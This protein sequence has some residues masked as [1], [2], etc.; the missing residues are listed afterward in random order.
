MHATFH[1]ILFAGAALGAVALTTPPAAA[2]DAMGLFSE[3]NL[4]PEVLAKV[5]ERA[6][7]RESEV[8]AAVE[9]LKGANPALA[10]IVLRSIALPADID[11]AVKS[12]FDA[13]ALWPQ[14]ARLKLCFLDG[15]DA[16]RG[17]V[18]E[19]AAQVFE[20]TN[21][22]L[23]LGD[24]RLHPTGRAADPRHVPDPGLLELYRHRREPDRVPHADVRARKLRPRAELLA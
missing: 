2:H 7:K 3:R 1:S 10:A 15:D 19:V 13:R 9:E 5:D 8:T 24:A 21:L 18:I 12:V 17:R 20:H 16:A 23:E 4:P 22:T 6:R 11:E 14:N